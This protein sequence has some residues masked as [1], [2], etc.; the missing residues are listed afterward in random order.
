MNVTRMF[1]VLGTIIVLCAACSRKENQNE[2]AET[3][4][5]STGS[6]EKDEQK[7]AVEDTNLGKD[8]TKENFRD[9]PTSDESIFS[10]KTTDN[11]I[12]INS[13]KRDINDRVIVVPET[14]NGNRVVSIGFGA[15]T[16]IENAEAIVLPDTVERIGDG[17]FTGCEKLKYVYLGTG[18]KSTGDAMFNYCNSLKE[19]EL[20]EGMTTMNGR[21]AGRCS[22]LEIITVPA[23]VTEIKTG[24]IS[25]HEFEGVIRTPAGSEAEKYAIE[26][27]LK[28]ENY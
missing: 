14:I 19:I 23:T 24:I 3:T 5:E 28:V 4:Q 21:I 15:F 12:E 1:I 18:L 11:G 22:G 25:V 8:V 20:P 7:E 13:C 26:H 6:S 17:A 16:E 2:V 27:G 9:F 10:V